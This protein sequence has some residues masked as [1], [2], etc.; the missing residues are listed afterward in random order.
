MPIKRT[1]P[2]AGQQTKLA[3]LVYD[4]DLP[5][6]ARANDQS[7]KLVDQFNAYVPVDDLHING[8][9]TLGENIADLGGLLVA[10]DAFKLTP[11]GKSNT[12]IDGLSPDQRFFY[13]YAQIWRTAQRPA[14][15]RLQVQSNEHAPAK[16]RTNGPLADVP[17]FA[18]AFACKAGNPMQRKE[19]EQVKIWR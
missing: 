13:A 17:A 19:D 16:F 14:Q 2:R 10:Y 4:D 15:L 11:Q 1:Q 5:A 3:E 9:L 8:K 6:E 7:T 18:R 12:K